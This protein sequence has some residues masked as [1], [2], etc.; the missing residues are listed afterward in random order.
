MTLRHLKKLLTTIFIYLF[1]ITPV[2]SEPIQKEIAFEGFNFN[3]T[4]NDSTVTINLNGK[5]GP[6]KIHA[7]VVESPTRF[8][9]DVL[10]VA[11]KTARSIDLKG[12]VIERIRVGIHKDKTRIVFDINPSF[13]NLKFDEENKSDPSVSSYKYLYSLKGDIGT[14][15]TLAEKEAEIPT[16]IPSATPSPKSTSTLTPTPTITST[17]TITPTAIATVTP[18]TTPK[19]TA[20]KEPATPTSTP[21]VTNTPTPLANEITKD[22]STPEESKD[23]IQV[24][25]PESKPEEKVEATL[26][27]SKPLRDIDQAILD[28]EKNNSTKKTILK[29]VVFQTTSDNIQSSIAVSLSAIDPYT[30]NQVSDSKYILELPG[31]K[32]RAPHLSL[33]QY[34]PDSFKGFVYIQAEETETASSVIIVVDPG[35]KLIAEVSQGKLWIKSK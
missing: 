18:T 26:A 29:N 19:A 7:E 3:L 10:G 1:F 31:T 23:K 5:Q 9:I 25:L 8:F 34:P 32:L 4:E 12:Q 27:N 35:V 6:L 11:S 21:T 30:L 13:T 33:P 17:P 14:A 20:T 28:M 22:F 24:K 16:I 15:P 2:F